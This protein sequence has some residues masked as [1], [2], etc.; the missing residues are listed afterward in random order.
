MDVSSGA[1]PVNQRTEPH[2]TTEAKV[3]R[4]LAIYQAGRPDRCQHGVA[5]PT[6]E[7]AGSEPA[8]E[9]LG[10]TNCFATPAT[11]E[12]RSPMLGTVTH[13]VIGRLRREAVRRPSPDVGCTLIDGEHAW[14]PCRM[15][16]MR[17]TSPA[18]QRACL[19]ALAR[20]RMVYVRV[21]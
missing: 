11:S 1:H 7:T 3:S 16:G 18:P 19:V 10:P 15:H 20:P 13:V 21:S 5:I 14:C 9:P 4:D 17:Q 2:A 6:I 8:S 12:S